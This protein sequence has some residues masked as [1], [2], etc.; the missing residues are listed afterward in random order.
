MNELRTLL[1]RLADGELSRRQFLAAA[2]SLGI[3]PALAG[4]IARDVSVVR[5]QEARVGPAAD[6]L[7][8]AAYNVDQA[9]LNIANGDMDL[10]LFG[11]KASGAQDLAGSPDV[12]LIQAPATLYSLLLNPAPAPQGQLNPFSIR[13][14]RRAMQHLVD[15]TFIANDIFQGRALEVQ[16]HITPLDY[17]Q[18]TIF[19][20]LTA[21]NLR[22]DAEFAK[23]QIAAAM[24]ANGAVLGGDGK[25]S[26]NGQPIVLK[27]V[28]RVEDE[29]RDTGDLIRTA[30]EGAG[31]TVQPQ[32]QQ[33]GPATLAV[34]A[35]DPATFQWHLYTEGWGRGSAVRYDQGG[36]NSYNAPWLGNMPGWLQVGFWQYEQQQLDELGKRLYR[37]EFKSREERDELYRQ[38]T[39]LAIDESVRVWLAVALQSFPVRNEVVDLTEDLVSGPKNLFALRGASVPG[40]N[41]LR[42]GHQW[43]WTERTTWN[44]IGGFGDVYSTDVYANLVDPTAITDPFTGLVRPFRADFSVETAGPDGTLEVPEDAVIWDPASSAWQPLGP[45]K[46]AVS[47]VT[48]SYAKFFAAPWHHGQPMTMADVVYSLAQ[49]YELAYNEAKVQIETAIGIA[50]RPVLET[51]VG[52]R[53]TG[54]DTLEVYVN[55]WHFEQSLIGGYASPV[56]LNT[57]WELLAAM[58][59]VVFTKRRGAYTDTTAARFTV[60]WISLVTESDARLVLRSV[61]ELKRTNALPAGVFEIGGTTLVTPEEAAARYEA[62]EAW[63]QQ[64]NM[65][66][67]SNGSFMLTKYDPPGQFAQLDAFRPEGY[68][69]TPEDFKL[70]VPPRVTIDPVSAPPVDLGAPISVPVKVN[71]PGE[72]AVQFTLVDPATPEIVTAGTAPMNPNGTATIEIG[73]DVTGTLFPGLYQL[74]ILASSTDIAQVA[75]Q[76]VDL[77]IGV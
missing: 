50:S 66:V 19:P 6:V 65:L 33:F 70:G 74:Y 43:V 61:Q 48:F 24:Q 63:F 35:S 52:Y 55:Y 32:Y 59:D 9:P 62:C 1:Q 47:K 16:S 67:I 51:F 42:V 17:D 14:V 39:Q 31:F 40:R 77:N 28:T 4:T 41:D 45:G 46:T 44:P 68:P 22:Y 8:F 75:Q 69:F 29:R 37:G 15:R 20:V 23:G 10:Y 60:P 36:I 57:P 73:A 27:M 3:A 64:H 25:W 71:G 5:A 38:M 53:V 56:S 34:Y 2:A 76:R 11:L 21:A 12:R 72:L 54:P 26:V 30:L 18:L 13:E 58:D 7:T 49:N